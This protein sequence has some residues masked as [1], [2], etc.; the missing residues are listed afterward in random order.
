MPT[1]LLVGPKAPS[2]KKTIVS[3]LIPLPRLAAYRRRQGAA[4]A[5]TS[6]GGRDR[7]PAV[8]DVS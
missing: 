8:A 3:P 1:Q 4:R 6:R 7:G 2:G 5:R